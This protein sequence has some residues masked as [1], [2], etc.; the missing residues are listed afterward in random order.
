MIGETGKS[1]QE[2]M[3]NLNQ[4]VTKVRHFK[5]GKI[6]HYGQVIGIKEYEEGKVPLDH[7]DHFYDEL[8]RVIKL[9]KYE[10][11]FSKPTV[12]IYSYG[13]GGLKVLESVWFDRYGKIENIHRYRYD[14]ETGL[15]LERFEYNREGSLFYSIRSA[16]DEG[17]NLIEESWHRKNG[18]LIKRYKYLYY[19]DGELEQEENYDGQDNL[20]G[21]YH[22]TYD[23]RGNVREKSWYNPAGML[24]SKFVYICD[25][26][27]RV[28]KIE[29]FDGKENLEVSQEFK[30]DETGN[31][32]EE[33]W[34]D[35]EKKPIKL[36]KYDP[37]DPSRVYWA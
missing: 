28:I 7:Q 21:L 19:P 13:P 18:S 29:L 3:E 25:A 23:E 6:D 10:R 35:A 4:Q 36:L 32:L 22:F 2:F 9:E 30:Y 24:M 15:M 33:K 17:N 20:V 11:E 31:L 1:L 8:E 26:E 16:Y 37:N 12:R 34:L 14:S 27:D 5:I